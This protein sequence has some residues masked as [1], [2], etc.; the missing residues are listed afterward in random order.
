M[1]IVSEKKFLTEEELQ[2]VK[3]IQQ[4]T[5]NLIIELGEIELTKIQLSN[6]YELAKDFL[7][8]VATEEKELTEKLLEIYGKISINPEDG[9]ITPMG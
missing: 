4:K 9:E 7:K 3:T 6:R 1:S 5:Q 2:T 8:G